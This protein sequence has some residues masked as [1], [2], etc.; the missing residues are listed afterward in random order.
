MRKSASLFNFRSRFKV[1]PTSMLSVAVVVF[2]KK[3]SSFVSTGG[4]TYSVNLYCF[5]ASLRNI[6]SPSHIILLGSLTWQ[7]TESVLR[8]TPIG[9]EMF[10]TG[11]N[12]GSP[13]FTTVTS[14]SRKLLASRTS[15][16]KCLKSIWLL[17][18][19]ACDKFLLTINS[20]TWR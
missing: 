7:S 10:R 18:A 13:L 19:K 3:L 15:A 16:F 4:L 6:S 8:L 2:R 5:V 1:F 17:S 11:R 20:K 9:N 12:A 14:K